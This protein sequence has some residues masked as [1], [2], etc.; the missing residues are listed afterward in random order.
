MKLTDRAVAQL[1]LPPGKSEV[2]AFDDAIVGL[3]YRMRA[4]GG[5][6]WVFQSGKKRMT[7][8]KAG[9]LDTNAAR[10]A[11]KAL[12]GRI[13]LGQ[14][15]WTDKREAKTR[16]AESFKSCLDTYLARR[17]NDPRL[18][19]SSYGE[20]ERH[21]AK[22][23]RSLHGTPIAELNRRAIAIEIGR[24][25]NNGPVQANRTLTSLRKFLSWCAGEG[26]IESNP[27]QFVNQNPEASRTRVL[28]DAELRKLWHALPAS[29]FG[30]IVKLLA[31]TACRR[32]EIGGLRWSEVDFDTGVIALPPA[33]TKN[34]RP[35]VIPMSD[36][37]RTLLQ[38]QPRLEHR[39]LVFGSSEQRGFSG[40]GKRKERLDAA[41]Q[42]PPW[43]LHDLRRTAATGM[44][45]L[46]VQPHVVEAVLNHQSGSK[47]GVAGTY[48]KALYAGEKAYALARWDEHLSSITTGKASKVASLKQRA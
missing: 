42:I 29:D 45:N 36:S 20:I 13:A 8:G 19:A 35:H 47:A 9:A 17:R 22:N 23:L 15:P 48:N 44:A 39:N 25:A 4:E 30:V 41:L 43:T 7:I 2:I 34:G 3:G 33:R 26:L 11:A 32:D 5:R 6:S 21:L 38:G 12:A 16:A 27:A 18:R 10:A 31:L 24:L 46:G 28:T 14:T 1:Q 40:Y 37:V